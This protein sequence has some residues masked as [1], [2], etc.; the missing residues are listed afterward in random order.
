MSHNLERCIV[1]VGEGRG[2]R[3]PITDGAAIGPSPGEHSLLSLLAV[4]FRREM[5]QSVTMQQPPKNKVTQDE[6]GTTTRE[7][8]EDRP[9]Y[10]PRRKTPQRQGSGL[11]KSIGGLMIV[12]AIFWGT[13]LVTNGAD[14]SA[15]WQATGPVPLCGLGVVVSILG[16]YLRY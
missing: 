5:G 9:T 7:A 15:L 4:E 11:I 8:Y 10:Q 14:P 3:A 16:K 6:W 12:G 2:H 1:I 13:Y